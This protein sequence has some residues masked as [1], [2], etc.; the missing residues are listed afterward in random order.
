VPLA[1]EMR[2][3]SDGASTSLMSI[4]SSMLRALAAW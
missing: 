1:D 4:R 2:D 3:G